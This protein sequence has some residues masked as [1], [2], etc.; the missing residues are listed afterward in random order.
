MVEDVRGHE[1]LQVLVITNHRD[2]LRGAYKP[3][4]HVTEGVDEGEEFLSW[5]S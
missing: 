1:I 3:G 5:T 2:W 4:M